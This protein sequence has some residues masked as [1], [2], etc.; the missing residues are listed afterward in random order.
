M[1]QRASADGCLNYEGVPTDGCSQ[2]YVGDIKI[3][4]E[5]VAASQSSHENEDEDLVE[6]NE[7]PISTFPS[8]IELQEF[9]QFNKK[10]EE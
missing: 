3:K 2:L 8:P 9:D 6:N 10:E 5:S 7:E 4:F 1:D